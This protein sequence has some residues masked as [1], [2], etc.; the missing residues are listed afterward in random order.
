MAKPLAAWRA[1]AIGPFLPWHFPHSSRLDLPMTDQQW[2][3]LLRILDGETLT[4]LPAGLIIDSPWL[5]GW[6]GLSVM[7]YFSDDAGWLSANLAAES[8]FPDMLFLPGFWSEYGMCTEPSA[9]GVPCVF[10]ENELPFAR[11]I[12]HD[13]AEVS[14][15]KKPNCKTDGLLP[16]AM[17]R[18]HHAQQR[19]EAAGHAI[20]FASSRGPFNVATYLMGHTELLIGVKTHPQEIHKLLEI[21]TEFTVDW[22]QYQMA[23]FPSID[24]ILILDDLIGFLGEDDFREFALPYFKRIAESAPVRVKALH[25]DCHGLITARLM[26]EMGF[27][28]LNFSFEHSLKEIRELAGEEVILLGNIP[29]RDVLALGA[30]EDVARAVTEAIDSIDDRRRIIFSAGGGTPPGVSS[31]NLDA[32]C[33]AVADHRR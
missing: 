1:A 27:N 20:R 12:L 19:I 8:R 31:A 7:D 24:G 23:S 18:L 6:H 10:P 2:H 28:L 30:P 15:L 13:F 29:P 21:V 9:F 26:G 5:A 16:F 32:F 11:K 14:R 3:D 4:P 17:K 33:A 25:N 22:L